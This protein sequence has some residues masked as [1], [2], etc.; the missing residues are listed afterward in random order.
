MFKDNNETS[1]Y[2]EGPLLQTVKWVVSLLKISV[3]ARN[4][5]TFL[6][7]FKTVRVY[8]FTNFFHFFEWKTR[9]LIH[10]LGDLSYHFI[11]NHTD[12]E[13]IFCNWSFV[14]VQNPRFYNFRLKSYV[15]RIQYQLFLAFCF[16]AFLIIQFIFISSLPL[17]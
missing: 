5:N 13:C 10:L 14:W 7:Q 9:P 17:V 2:S 4:R 1:K 12:N 3:K 16:F 15:H 6:K 11:R 8:S